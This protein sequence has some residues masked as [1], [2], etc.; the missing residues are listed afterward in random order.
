MTVMMRTATIDVTVPSADNAPALLC[1]STVCE[2]PSSLGRSLRSYLPSSFLPLRPT[3]RFNFLDVDVDA[4]LRSVGS[5][6]VDRRY[7]H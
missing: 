2:R 7:R 5:A 1:Y 6:V 3:P 4:R